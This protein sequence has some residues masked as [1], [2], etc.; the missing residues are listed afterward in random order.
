MRNLIYLICMLFP[1][2]LKAQDLTP[3]RVYLNLATKHFGMG[4]EIFGINGP[5]EINPGFGLAWDSQFENVSY[6]IGLYRDSFTQ[7]TLT[8]GISRMMASFDEFKFIAG[9]SV[10]KS[11]SGDQEFEFADGTQIVE[12]RFYAWPYLQLE[13]KNMYTQLR[14]GVNNDIEPAGVFAFGLK[15]DIEDIAAIYK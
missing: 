15:F 2:T 14:A 3:D 7:P 5:N 12:A 11:L 13:Y 1:L 10:T 6:N 8:M 4:E 9:L